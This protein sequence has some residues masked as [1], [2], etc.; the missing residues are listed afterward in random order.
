MAEVVF[1]SSDLMFGSRVLGAARAIGVALRMVPAVDKLPADA[2]TSCG[3]VLLDLGH[4][5]HDLSGL[6]AGV[7]AAAPAARIIAYGAHV[8]EAALSAA[9]AA[10]CDQVLTRG[11]FNQQYIALLQAAKPA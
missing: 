1:L 10:G 9:R 5:T 7:R 6:V 2:A 3:L 11:Q 4:A 8:D